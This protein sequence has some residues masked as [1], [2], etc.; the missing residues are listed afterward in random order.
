MKN[1]NITIYGDGT[2]SRDF[3]YIGNVVQANIMAACVDTLN[4]KK[5]I[6]NIAFAQQ[7]SLNSLAEIIRDNLHLAGIKTEKSKVVYKDFRK[8]DVK[9]SLASI[10]LAKKALG[11]SPNFSLSEGLKA[12]IPWYIDKQKC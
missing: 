3:C 6:F 9:H 12:S 11:Y 2:T 7:T 1:K 5:N 8:G 10:D 4:L